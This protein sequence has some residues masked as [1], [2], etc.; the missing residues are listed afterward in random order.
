MRY[1][2]LRLPD[3]LDLVESA[4]LDD[5]REVDLRPVASSTAC[6]GELKELI[7]GAVGGDVDAG[8]DARYS[9]PLT[10]TD[11]TR[12]R[13]A[14]T[15]TG[16]RSR[17]SSNVLVRGRA[18]L[19]ASL[20]PIDATCTRCPLLEFPLGL[21]LVRASI[22]DTLD[23]CRLLG[24]LCEANLASLSNSRSFCSFLLFGGAL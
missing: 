16:E 6:T 23:P 8:T 12:A 22:P 10:F 3:W 2:I 24:G 7:D 17:L 5:A 1:H 18:L 21:L 20:S 4:A 19:V 9:A 11:P 14:A 13:L 15:S